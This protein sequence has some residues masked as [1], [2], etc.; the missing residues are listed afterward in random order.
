MSEN[1]EELATIL[2]PHYKLDYDK[3]EITLVDS[4][5]ATIEN[6]QELATVLP[7]YYKLDLANGKIEI[8]SVHNETV[9]IL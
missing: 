5:H 7:S 6:F 8:M 3:L 1:L 4:K 9:T 2:P